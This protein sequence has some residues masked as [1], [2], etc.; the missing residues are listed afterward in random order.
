ML[1]HVIGLGETAA[2]FIPDGSPTIGVNDVQGCDY[3]VCVDR[4]SAFTMERLE[5][6]KSLKPKQFFTHLPD[7]DRYHSTTQLVLKNINALDG[8]WAAFTPNS[9]NSPFVACAVAYKYLGATEIRLWGVDFNTH[10]HLNGA[11]RERSV[12]DF[13]L[14]KKLLAAKG[15]C[16]VPHEGSYLFGRI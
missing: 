16:I 12:Q 9:N 6:I 1:I 14:L 3:Q 8:R 13:V 7:W 11:M 10:T 15:C 2:D 4:P 5:I